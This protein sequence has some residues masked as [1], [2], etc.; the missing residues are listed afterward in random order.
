MAATAAGLVLL[1]VGV[2][3][4]DPGDELGACRSQLNGKP[5]ITIHSDRWVRIAVPKFDS[6]EGPATITSFSAM[7]QQKNGLLVTNGK[8]VKRS[9]DAGCTWDTIFR[10][11]GIQAPAPGYSADVVTQVVEPS[12]STAWLTTYDDINGVPHPHVYV[13]SGITSGQP[14]FNQSDVGLPTYGTPA[15][16]VV[17][18]PGL[19]EAYLLV[20]ELPDPQSGPAAVASRH[21][22]ATRQPNPPQSGTL[23]PQP[24]GELG[25][26]SGFGR[27]DGL[28]R[29]A[30][31]KIW[32]WS[33]KQYAWA[34]VDPSSSSP[35]WHT[36]TA[37][38]T[39][40][41][42]D[43]ETSGAVDVIEQTASGAVLAQPT[44]QGGLSTRLTIPLT[45]YAF[46][47]G[48][49][50]DVYVA[51]GAK[52]TFG[53]DHLLHRWINITPRGGP[54]FH[55]LKM[56]QA[57][58]ARIVLGMSADALWRWDTFAQ[59][60]FVPPP[61]PPPATGGKPTLPHSNL[62]A[63]ILTPTKKVVT[64]APGTVGKVPVMLQV[65]PDPTPLDVY[66]LVDTT[67]SMA[68]AIIGLQR[69]ILGLSRDLRRQ[70]GVDACFGVG[71]VKDTSD[72][73]SSTNT[74]DPA[75]NYVFKTFLPVSPC[76]T[77]P[78]LDLVRAATLKLN[79]GGGGDPPEA[80]TLGLSLAVN[81]Q[82]SP[83]NLVPQPQPANFRPGV[84]KVIVYISDQPSH[85]A[86][87]GFPTIP[88]VVQTLNTNDV[89]IVSIAVDH[90]G[91]DLNGAMSNMNQL[92][93]GTGSYAP[94]SGVD[95]NGDGRRD[96]GDLGPGA[97]L[98]CQ[99]MVTSASDGT[100]M[101]N[102]EP[103]IFGLLLGV[104]DP[105]T[106]QVKIKD[107]NHALR[108][109]IQGLTSDVVDMK[110]QSGL[111]FTLPVGCAPSQ[112]GKTLPIYLSPFVRSQPVASQGEVDVVCKLQPK[113]PPPPVITEAAPLVF[114]P[115]A[116]PPV[117][118]APPV[119]PNP[120]MQPATNL[121]PNAGMAREEQQQPQL[122]M[123]AQD[124]DA[125][126]GEETEVVEMSA[127][128]N[129]SPRSEAMFLAGAAV[130]MSAAAGCAMQ[131]RRRTA[132][133]RQG[134]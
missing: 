77:S 109:R 11:S 129:P 46:T 64:L 84:F 119:P 62:K 120:P 67:A 3:L 24:W 97:P 116:R 43:V 103:A 83:K 41:T 8:V 44:Q 19:G 113:L 111:K 31:N 99:E 45:P 20:D 132:Y 10:S 21:L 23:A 108:G 33:G 48:T 6:D 123:A 98:V 1:T 126:E 82:S 134:R 37:A 100:Q 51:S 114:L 9:V 18:F 39:I 15:S 56:A 81:G 49:Y 27:V 47:H 90:V 72:P 104:K 66:F 53:F 86:E 105:G 42:I 93:E 22:Y 78:D 54:A 95:C 57:T 130:L 70:L 76:D 122:A 69:A 112:V 63:P 32:I 30:S 118:V 29:E 34:L 101:V 68:P 131:L 38:G 12:D 2:T 28:A 133:V 65:P 107:P 91:G 26:P 94:A 92:A 60:T 13:G 117:A 5:Q 96:Y 71:G 85:Q 87:Q 55:V 35:E 102:M 16:L 106:L 14:T 74:T 115:A 36:F 17:P 50:Q 75:S 52:G 7:P 121:N 40:S 25:L 110:F 61:P 4:A 58:S 124:A 80:Q 79:Q 125:A 88:D 128:R 127:M 59:E 73:T 89:K